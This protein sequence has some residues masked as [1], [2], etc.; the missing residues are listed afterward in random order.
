MKERPLEGS[1]WGRIK[2]PG[3]GSDGNHEEWEERTVN[4]SN[5]KGCCVEGGR[6]QTF[7]WTG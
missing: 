6:E 2:D 7:L 1:G 3:P 5:R 4:V